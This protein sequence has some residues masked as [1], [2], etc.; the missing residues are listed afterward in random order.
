MIARGKFGNI[1]VADTPKARRLYISGELQGGAYFYPDAGTVVPGLSGPGPVSEAKYSLGWLIAGLT[2]PCASVVMVG[3]GAGTGVVQL[4]CNFPDIDVTVVEID[5]VI[6]KT[7]FESFPLLNYYA[8]TGRLNIVVE[9]AGSFFNRC[10]WRWDIGMAD[11]YTGE[12]YNLVLHYFE[13]LGRSVDSLYV[14]AIDRFGGEMFVDILE[15][16]DS[17]GHPVASVFQPNQLDETG[18]IK[19]GCISNWLFTDVELDTDCLR[20][21]QPFPQYTSGEV[22]E[23]REHW[24]QMLSASLQLL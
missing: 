9:D 8:D 7:A 16:M 4:L 21:W 1:T 20:Q 13:G 6:V 22:D 3:L 15:L 5:P 24:Q 10:S 11:A 17:V 12:S 2:R 19:T 18:T 23:C 14:N